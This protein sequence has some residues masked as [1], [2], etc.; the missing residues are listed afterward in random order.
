M[1]AEEDKYSTTIILHPI[2]LFYG[3]NTC[4]FYS[5]GCRGVSGVPWGD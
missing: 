2:L 1:L 3:K 4:I 5:V